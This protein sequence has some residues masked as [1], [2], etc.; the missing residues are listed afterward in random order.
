MGHADFIGAD[1]GAQPQVTEDEST[2]LRTVRLGFRVRRLRRALRSTI[3]I[4]MELFSLENRTPFATCAQARRGGLRGPKAS[5][6]G[7]GRKQK[8]TSFRFLATGEKKA[9]GRAGAAANPRIAGLA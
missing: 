2:A 6:G 1:F 5:R 7:T 8:T 3:H 4:L 9:G